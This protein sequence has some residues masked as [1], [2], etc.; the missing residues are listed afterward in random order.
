MTTCSA[1]QWQEACVRDDL[2]LDLPGAIAG[3]EI[4][5]FYQPVVSLKTNQLIGMEVLARWMHPK[6]GLLEPSAF[7]H[8]VEEHGLCSALTRA[9]LQ[10]V[11]TDALSWPGYWT[12]A[13]NTSPNELA[14]VLDF[15][16]MSDR[17]AG[18]VI[19]GG[20]VELEVTETAMM[21][22]LALARISVALMR[23]NGVKV[24]LDD[25]GSGYA[26]FNQLC[27]IPFSRLKIDKS[28]ITQMMDDTRVQA[29]A[30]A[31][32]DLAHHLGMTVTAEG[33][34]SLTLAKRLAE[35]GCDHA[36]GFYFG[37]PVPADAISASSV[38]L[39]ST[40]GDFG[41]AA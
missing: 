25:F 4:V 35:M 34:E 38:R 8:S 31:I 29:C 28:L 3:G 24:V 32:I 16:E 14:A 36:Q 41:W 19:H 1:R 17:I 27:Q 15:I 12:F 23:S 2:P 33:V 21:Q 39:A 7:I 18:D 10:T 37:R 13:F 40:D 11:R 20:R 6:F 9:L 30:Q 26:N 22:D 5:P